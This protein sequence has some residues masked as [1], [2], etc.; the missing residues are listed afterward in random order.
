LGPDLSQIGKKYSRAQL[1]ESILEPSKQIDPK[2]VTYLVETANGRVVSGLLIEKTDKEVLL[3]D[4]Q[5][6]EIRIAAGEIELLVPAQKS[7]MPE[8][9]LRDMTAEQVADLIEFLGSLR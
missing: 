6:K 5:N 8:L 2:Y 3:K 4:A 1:L 9:L 7:L